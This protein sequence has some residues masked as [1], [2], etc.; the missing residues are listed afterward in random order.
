MDDVKQK[1]AEI[2]KIV[3]RQERIEAYRWFVAREPFI[4]PAWFN[5]AV[6]LADDLRFS[7][8]RHAALRGFS[9]DPSRR[10]V[11]R[12]TRAGALVWLDDCE[13]LEQIHATERQV[14]YAAQ[15]G[16]NKIFLRALPGRSDGVRSFGEHEIYSRSAP[17][18]VVVAALGVLSAPEGMMQVLQFVAGDTFHELFVQGRVDLDIAVRLVASAAASAIAAQVAG[19]PPFEMRPENLVRSDD[20]SRGVVALG[21]FVGAADAQG[22]WADP[23]LRRGRPADERTTVYQLGLLLYRATM[24]REPPLMDQRGVRGFDEA[25]ATWPAR[26]RSLIDLV[27]Q[28][29]AVNG[30]DRPSLRDWHRSLV[31][32]LQATPG[33]ISART[34]RLGTVS[35][36]QRIGEG[37]FGVV[38]AGEDPRHGVCAVKVL[39]PHFAVDG[40]MLMR[41]RNEGRVAGEIDHEGVVP[42][43]GGGR[44]ND[45]EE[46]LVM[47]Y[48]AGGSLESW[49]AA[50]SMDQAQVAALGIRVASATAAAHERGVVHR[51][52]KPSNLLLRRAG[53]L[54]SVC[55]ADFGIAKLLGEPGE[56]GTPFTRTGRLLGTPQYMAPEQWRMECIDQRTDVYALGVILYRCLAGKVPFDARNE[57]LLQQAHLSAAPGQLGEIG[58]ESGLEAIVAR[59]LAKKPEDRFHSMEDVVAAMSSWQRQQTDLMAQTRVEPSPDAMT[60]V[61]RVPRPA[62]PTTEQVAVPDV[63]DTAPLHASRRTI[64]VGGV[65]AATVIGFG[66]WLVSRGA[67]RGADGDNPSV[68]PTPLAKPERPTPLE[69]TFHGWL[70]G[71]RLYAIDAMYGDSSGQLS[72]REIYDT[73]G[74][75]YMVPSET[76]QLRHLGAVEDPR[77][78]AWWQYAKPF[79]AF[80]RKVQLGAGLEWVSAPVVVTG[81]RKQGAQLHPHEIAATTRGHSVSWSQ[82]WTDDSSIDVG[83]RNRIRV[84]ARDTSDAV[85]IDLG[86]PGRAPYPSAAVTDIALYHAGDLSDGILLLINERATDGGTWRYGRSFFRRLGYQVVLDYPAGKVAEAND[87]ANQLMR[88]LGIGVTAIRE[89]A[90]A[91]KATS[92]EVYFD[93]RRANQCRELAESIA[94]VV[95]AQAVKPF[96]PEWIDVLVFL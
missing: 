18:S 61:R 58:V 30:P 24:A 73:R 46:Y 64:V 13:L 6:D 63:D 27:R 43:Y 5:L 48:M 12:A 79:G 95:G 50:N 85:I 4:A 15:R 49:L 36:R 23:E 41:F 80:A 86:P 57:Y 38:Y 72:V 33:D 92:G 44:G 25:P 56:P 75:L 60:I 90:N 74:A 28:A 52:L 11:D 53:D 78:I 55:V 51:D 21:P 2:A 42:T 1:F 32:T 81:T 94:R 69:V 29:A 22:A 84:R 68:P 9:I 20:L 37:Q 45:G 77:L 87:R 70:S 71:T 93:E 96:K 91:S 34:V 59:M 17:A 82:E 54:R 76:Y 62:A 65:V 19:L 40:E 16:G 88:S 3:V 83:D 89:R 7:E 66:A 26:W 10:L 35:V 14:L 39:H 31:A 8:A 47:E 67:K